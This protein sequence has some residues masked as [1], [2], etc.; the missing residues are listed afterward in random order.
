MCCLELQAKAYQ[1]S[2]LEASDS[3][4]EVT[5][6]SEV[7]QT[8]LLPGNSGRL[9]LRLVCAG[10]LQRADPFV[11]PQTWLFILAWSLPLGFS[12]LAQ[13]VKLGGEN[14][15]AWCW[16]SLFFSSGALSGEMITYHPIFW[17]KYSMRAC[18]WLSHTCLLLHHYYSQHTCTWHGKYSAFRLIIPVHSSW[19]PSAATK[20]LQKF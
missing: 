6:V 9:G 12:I 20:A 3:W 1:S 15:Y 13:I 10:R 4:L 18:P 14:Q 17:L 5:D 8:L 19:N 2:I 7:G 16:A 11:T